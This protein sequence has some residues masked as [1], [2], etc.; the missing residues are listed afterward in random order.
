MQLYIFHEPEF[1]TA[2][3]LAITKHHKKPA[4]RKWLGDGH[5][6]SHDWFGWGEILPWPSFWID[7]NVR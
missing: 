1:D 5:M 3:E 2:K 7:T 6:C 4:G